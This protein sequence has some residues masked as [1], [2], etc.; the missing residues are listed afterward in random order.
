MLEIEIKAHCDNHGAVREKILSLGGILQE[1]LRECDTYFN[2]PSRNFASTDEAVRIRNEG[3]K[4]ILTYKGPK[5]GGRSK[6]R[7]EVEVEFKDAD[8]MRCILEKLGFAAIGEIVKVR[9]LYILYDVTI[10]LDNVE[11][12][13]NFVELEKIDK[14]RDKVENELFSIAE[15]LGLIRFERRSY[16]E[17]KLAK[18]F[19]NDKIK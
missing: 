9:E 18:T 3:E 5:L 8:S 17:M 1:K 4:N 6:T 10:C 19:I 11:G 12:L 16:L 13:G 2:H 7:F 15:N 14:D